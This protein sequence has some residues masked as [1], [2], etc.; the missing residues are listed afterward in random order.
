M[1]NTKRKMY[2]RNIKIAD[3]DIPDSVKQI[4]KLLSQT[5]KY[6]ARISNIW[7]LLSTSFG[8][9]EFELLNTA[10]NENIM[11]ESYLIDKMIEW[12]SG[13]DVDFSEIAERI[14]ASQ[15]FTEKEKVLV[16]EDEE[17]IGLRLWAIFLS[18][19][20]PLY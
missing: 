11:L 20:R 5:F 18:I 14:K 2:A 8:L 10:T 15:E 9:S 3:K 4:W 6:T 17:E 16:F 7:P 19:S 13:K 1:D 12:Q